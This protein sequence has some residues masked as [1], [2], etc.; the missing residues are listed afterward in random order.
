MS[1]VTG[2]SPQ[3]RSIEELARD[4]VFLARA[5]D[6]FPGLQEALALPHKRRG[7]L[8]LMA[9][10]IA[11]GGL[12]G[13]YSG[14][15]SGALI[16]AVKNPPS[17]VPGLPNHYATAHMN[18]GYALGTV[19]AH[20]MGRPIKVEGNPNHPSSLGATDVFA[21]AEVLSF[22]DP[23]RAMVVSTGGTPTARQTM[24]GAIVSQQAIVAARNGEGFR[25]LTGSV[26][27]PTI[28]KL[29]QN[30]LQRYPE[31]RWH[32]WEPVHRDNVTKG[33]ELAY[34]RA[35]DVIPAL[36]KV[37]V[38]L[39]IDSDLL[40]GAPGWVR[41]AREFASRRNPARTKAMSRV[42]A[43][44][45]SPT[46]LG[47]VADNRFVA[48]PRELH[49]VV[50]ALAAAILRNAAPSSSPPWLAEVIADLKA[51]HGKALID[52][53]PAQPPEAH[54]LV[55]AMNEALGARGST[56]QLIEPVRADPRHG[57]G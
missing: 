44:E 12:A 52:A 56:M 20:Q 6:E 11:M 36:D 4:P 54:A 40:H 51:A 53:G 2:A 15:P 55:H 46:L 43:V 30:L 7:V 50:T 31:A 28:S 17:I 13:C 42:Y 25:I 34:G 49:Q 29:I 48:G 35:V 21:Q 39:G 1:S 32:S 45:P 22:Y 16:P 18:A 23:D 26:T 10:A 38:L 57:T 24:L 41:Y 33:A 19:V 14:E 27:S 9:A 5:A 3:W 8:R 37:D 47:S